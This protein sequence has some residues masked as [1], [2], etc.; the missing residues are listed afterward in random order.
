MR[1]PQTTCLGIKK[2]LHYAT[3][4]ANTNCCYCY[5]FTMPPRY[6]ILNLSDDTTASDID[7]HFESLYSG[8]PERS[9]VF[10]FDTTGIKSLTLRTLMRI[11][12]VIHKY[13][14]QSDRKLVESH[15]IVPGKYVYNLLRGFIAMPFVR[16]AR[17]VHLHRDREFLDPLLN[18]TERT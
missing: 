17:P 12:P 2:N 8:A 14:E 15:V 3:Q 9:L 16:T 5:Y 1:L 7:R 11:I 6:V 4:H 18:V 10:V 13:K